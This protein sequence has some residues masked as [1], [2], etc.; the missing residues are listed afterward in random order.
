[1]DPW[2][3]Y[4]RFCVSCTRVS[5][6]STVTRQLIDHLFICSVAGLAELRLTLILVCAVI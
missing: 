6:L 1:M 4:I 2:L 5:I 3:V